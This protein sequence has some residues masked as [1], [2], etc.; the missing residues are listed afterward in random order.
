MWNLTTTPQWTRA[1]L[2][3]HKTIQK[4]H[5]SCAKVQAR[6]LAAFVYPCL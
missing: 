2:M 6:P 4:Q 5:I 3:L 1:A